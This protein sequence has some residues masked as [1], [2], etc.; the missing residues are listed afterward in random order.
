MQNLIVKEVSEIQLAQNP[1][2]QVTEEEDKALRRPSSSASTRSSQRPTFLRPGSATG[3]IRKLAQPGRIMI[4]P[5][6]LGLNQEKQSSLANNNN[7]L[8][9]FLKQE[10]IVPATLPTKEKQ[11]LLNIPKQ[12]TMEKEPSPSDEKSSQEEREP[13]HLL[14][15]KDASAKRRQSV[16]RVQQQESLM[17]GQQPQPQEI[18]LNPESDKAKSKTTTV[19]TEAPDSRMEDDPVRLWVR[20]D[21]PSYLG[22]F[23]HSHIF[24]L[25]YIQ[26][27]SVIFIY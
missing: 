18:M 3:L 20:S 4:H 9:P 2:P 5:Q 6:E 13:P 14:S 8:Q 1:K 26:S 24:I 22:I 7:P 17:C 27:Y 16:G 19:H 11:S 12:E 21:N 23:S 25:T 10:T 15:A